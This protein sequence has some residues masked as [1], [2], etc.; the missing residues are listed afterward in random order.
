MKNIVLSMLMMTAAQLAV[1]QEWMNM[2]RTDEN[3]LDCKIP[4]KIQQGIATDMSGNEELITTSIPKEDGTTFSFPFYLDEL[5]SISI[6]PS[7]LD[8][9]KGHNKYRPFV[10]NIFT[11]DLRDI[12]E[13]EEWINC[14]ITIDGKGEYSDFCGTGRIRGRG[15][16][17][18]EWY[19]KKPYKFKLDSKSKLLGLE[20]A[21][22]WN[23]LANYRDVTD[24]MNTF[25]FET[26]RSMGMPY[27]N[28]SRYVEVFL[29]HEYIGLYQLTEKI[30][31]KAN[32]IAMDEATSLLMSF[33]KDDG[34]ELSPEDR[35]NFWSQ[36]FKL[37]MCIKSPEGYT[38][39]QIDS[40]KAEFAVLEKA[41]KTRDIA[42]VE[43]LMDIPS[44]IS[45]LQM[46]EFLYNVEI[47]APRSIYVHKAKDGKYT[48][49]PVWDWD[50]GFDFD[51]GNM[52]YGH[53][54]FSDYR[55]LIYG[56]DP[57][58]YT[59]AEYKINKFWL[60]LFGNATFVKQY[61]E[62]WEHHTNAIVEEN[63]AETKKYADALTKEGAYD[64][65]SECWPLVVDDWW[66]TTTFY[67]A[68]ELRKMEQWIKNRKNY[69]DDVIANYPDGDDEIV[70]LY[71][72][73]VKTIQKSQT[74]TFSKGY[75][76]SG[77][78][79][80]TQ[81]DIT[82]ALGGEPTSLVPL[83][84]NDE[85]GSNTANGEYGAWFDED[86]NTN[87]WGQGHVYIESNSLYSW[88]FGCHPKNCQA[89]DRH[90]VTMQYRRGNNAVN[91]EV[92]FYVN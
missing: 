27:T 90:I 70:P 41:I 2:H 3:G 63:W 33:D 86:G 43:E 67:P 11:E 52:Y 10:M 57:V 55:E 91:V 65:D 50:A 14:L 68:T 51:W 54:F 79:N 45:L 74:I 23:L 6:V 53:T 48:F 40:I 12:E 62:A 92:T 49:G 73:V 38:Q 4:I 28:H 35:D 59:N 31:I 72:N 21:K 13:R 34:P 15:N 1:A 81:N 77:K 37:P 56:T 25:A 47:D 26:A 44:F 39:E 66:S 20:K 64:R 82:T 87:S 9:E 60:S 17:S 71:A 80:I 58:N 88:A 24:M 30:E 5:D 46:H 84:T 85:E 7:L 18:W 19:D 42:K 36:V 89:G 76:Q 75:S 29:N 83:D 69:L 16:S 22:N 61:K 32:R 78:I 8:T